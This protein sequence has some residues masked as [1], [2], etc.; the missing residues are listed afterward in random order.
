VRPFV[1]DFFSNGG[2]DGGFIQ[3]LQL[4]I[5]Q[6]LY[7]SGNNYINKCRFFSKATACNAKSSRICMTL[8][9]IVCPK[10]WWC[11]VPK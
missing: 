8:L 7:H 1:E 4:N 6:Y 2:G 9:L 5:P 10:A 11:N 3:Q